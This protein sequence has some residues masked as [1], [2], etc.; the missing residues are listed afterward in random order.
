MGL[1]TDAACTLTHTQTTCKKRPVRTEPTLVTL[2]RPCPS[3]SASLSSWTDLYSLEQGLFDRFILYIYVLV[4]VI[5]GHAG[6]LCR[7]SPWPW[8]AEAPLHGSA[9]LLSAV[10]SG[11]AEALGAQ[12][13]GA[14]AGRL[15]GCGL[16]RGTWN[17]PRPGTEPV[18]P[19]LCHQ[20]SF[21]KKT[22]H[23]PCCHTGHS[24]GLS[25]S[26]HATFPQA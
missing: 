3:G 15:S 13:S 8:R 20:A 2:K 11:G 6:A 25:R 7:G 17:L 10:L 21:K 1:L 12:A 23:T 4:F 19:A 14:A 9:R 5:S 18:P 22:A 26:T 24:S 16:L